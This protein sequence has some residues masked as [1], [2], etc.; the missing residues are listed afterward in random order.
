MTTTQAAVDQAAADRDAALKR[1]REAQQALR[2]AVNRC[3]PFAAHNYNSFTEPPEIG[4]IVRYHKRGGFSG[5]EWAFMKVTKITEKSI[6]GTIYDAPYNR[7]LP[8]CE[9]RI[10]RGVKPYQK[11]IPA[12]HFRET[13]RPYFA[14]RDE[15]NAAYMAAEAVYM[16]LRDELSRERIEQR[17]AE[18]AAER[19]A[20]NRKRFRIDQAIAFAE[21]QPHFAEWIEARMAEYDAKQGSEQ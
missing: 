10:A 6:L 15:A 19:N 12:Y 13:L 14:K 21:A 17:N 1:H 9:G 16:N 7:L 2:E 11:H 20:H 18:R 4:D 5:G 8:G 3:C